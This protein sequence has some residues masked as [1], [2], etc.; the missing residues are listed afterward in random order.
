MFDMLCCRS[1]YVV[2]RYGGEEGEHIFACPCD[3]TFDTS[4]FRSRARAAA[5][6]SITPGSS[7]AAG[8]PE[9]LSGRALSINDSDLYVNLDLLYPILIP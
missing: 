8:G 3:I 1:T 5:G 7:S 6:T 2:S 9:R 4:R